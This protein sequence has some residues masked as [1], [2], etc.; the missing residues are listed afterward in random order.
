MSLIAHRSDFPDE[1]R[2][3]AVTRS[4]LGD[5]HPA[6]AVRRV[7]GM[8]CSM[9]GI[10]SQWARP[11]I[12]SH[13]SWRSPRAVLVR[14]VSGWRGS[15]IRHCEISNSFKISDDSSQ[16]SEPTLQTAWLN[17]NRRVSGWLSV[18]T[19]STRGS[20]ISAAFRADSTEFDSNSH[21]A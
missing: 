20:R 14:S 3:N 4:S 9:G 1:S 17:R 5:G 11:L 6:R 15:S 8:G 18:K 7:T 16:K 2:P 10:R 13:C 12:R 21:R 19:C